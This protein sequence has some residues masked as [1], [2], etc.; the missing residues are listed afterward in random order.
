MKSS[1]LLFTLLTCLLSSACSSIVAATASG[2]I[3]EDYGK[4]TLGTVVEDNTIENKAYVNLHKAS[5]K[6]HEAHINIKSFNRVLLLTGE[7]PDTASKELASKVTSDIRHIRRI[8]NELEVSG[9]S[10]FLSRTNDNYLSTKVS[11]RLIATEGIDSGRIE[12]VVENSQLYLMGLV[13]REEADRVVNAMQKVSGITRIVKVFE[14]ID[15]TL[16]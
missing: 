5:E 13:T 10:S 12:T 4:R 8:H 15:S 2:P 11:S 3:E 1:L 16:E 7:V 14:Y 6:L 9:N